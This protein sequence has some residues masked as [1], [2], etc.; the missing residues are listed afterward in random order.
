MPWRPGERAWFE[1]RCLESDDSADAAL[2]HRSH[3]Q[4]TVTG[5]LDTDPAAA[6]M[7]AD[8][9]AE[10]GLPGTY[11]VLFADGH[12]GSA[13]EDELLAGPACY[14]RPDPPAGS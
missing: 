1:Y 8:E 9:R 10:A 2:W 11:P 3:Q 14:Q 7:T 12:T 13:W 5:P 4:V 6:G